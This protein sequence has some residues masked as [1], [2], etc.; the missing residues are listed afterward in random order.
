MGEGEKRRGRDE[1]GTRKR[2]HRREGDYGVRSRKE[3]G[4]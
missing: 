4:A 1:V 2:R 3:R